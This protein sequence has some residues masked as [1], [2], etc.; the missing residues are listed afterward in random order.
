M[1]GKVTP[2]SVV[3]LGPPGGTA[4]GRRRRGHTALLGWVQPGHWS[5][6]ESTHDNLG[7]ANHTL[8]RVEVLEALDTPASQTSLC[9][10][11]A[12]GARDLPGSSA[13]W[14]CTGAQRV[15]TASA[16]FH[17]KVVSAVCADST[18]LAWGHPLPQLSS[19]TP[20]PL[21]GTWNPGSPHCPAPCFPAAGSGQTAP[22]MLCRARFPGRAGPPGPE[23]GPP[24]LV[25]RRETSRGMTKAQG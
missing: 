14:P 19:S 4:G 6:V 3:G 9:Y 21:S 22:A 2:T 18:H 12:T 17:K 7:N 11:E 23:I 8:V 15:A 1:L 24:A 13:R 10:S 20:K 25:Q 16:A 5:P